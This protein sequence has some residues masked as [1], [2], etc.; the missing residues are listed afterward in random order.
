MNT[1]WHITTFYTFVPLE[2]AHV[3]ALQTMLQAEGSVRHLSGLLLVSKE[4][5]NGTI[6]GTTDDIAS[7]KKILEEAF[8]HMEFKDSTA[9]EQPFKR[10]KVKIREEIVAIGDT[11][12]YPPSK[13]N[14]HLTPTEWQKTIETEDVILLDTRNTYETCVGS[15]EGAID[16]KIQTFQEFPTFVKN[17]KLP[18]D[19]KILMYCTG[20]IRCE[21]ALVAMQKEGYENVYQL[22]GG[23][24]RYLAEFPFKSFTGECFVF[25]HRVAVD[26]TL[27][28][29][30][31]YGLCPHCGDA[32]DIKAP[33]LACTK[34]SVMC[35][36]CREKGE[37][38]ICSKNCND[39]LRRKDRRNIVQHATC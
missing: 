21:K 19:K 39:V 6:A 4:G 5:C 22:Q 28:P 26:Q 30:N 16:P 11:S 25:D 7:Y 12:V 35:E 10:F 17:A 9:A 34:E 37:L 8:G 29:S 38:Q 14:H 18:K 32:G 27:S 20:G 31:R 24:L 3:Q 13:H 1:P 36:L 33:C 2:D 23:I 15:F